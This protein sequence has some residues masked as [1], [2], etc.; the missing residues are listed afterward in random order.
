MSNQIAKVTWKGDRQFSGKT[1]TGYD[2]L[3]DGGSA[4]DGHR[5][6]PGPMELILQGL[7]GCSSVD[8]V[9]ILQ[10]KKLDLKA[11]EVEIQATRSQQI[12][13]VFAQINLHFIISGQGISGKAVNQAV[14]LSVDKYCSVAKMLSDGG[15]VVSHSFEIKPTC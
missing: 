15:V 3:M 14:S 12:P 7:A 9:T 1:A 6:A 2:V 4:V 11:C 5:I 8:V 10:K 13:A